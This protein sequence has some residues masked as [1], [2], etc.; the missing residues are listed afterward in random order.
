MN[1]YSLGFNIKD[2]LVTHA[3]LIQG[4]SKKL[5]RLDSDSIPHLW[6]NTV[7]FQVINYSFKQ[8]LNLIELLNCSM[9]LRK[10]F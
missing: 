8:T 4:M 6:S 5:P 7:N 9:I 3:I 2:M 1:W 10:Y